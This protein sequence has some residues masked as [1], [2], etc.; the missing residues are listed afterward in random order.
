[1]MLCLWI[2]EDRWMNK[3]LWIMLKPKMSGCYICNF[4]SWDSNVLWLYIEFFCLNSKKIV[5]HF[6][7]WIPLCMQLAPQINYDIQL[8]N[9]ALL[10]GQN[11]NYMVSKTITE[12]SDSSSVKQDLWVPG[13]ICVFYGV[14]IGKCICEMALE[15][16]VRKV[17]QLRNKQKV[18]TDTDSHASSNQM[19]LLSSFNLYD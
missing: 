15:H 1:M 17:K 12:L 16:K 8:Q 13:P 7:I 2:S 6:G 11:P 18:I 10:Q 14:F 19:V 9:F 4:L 5:L 3:V